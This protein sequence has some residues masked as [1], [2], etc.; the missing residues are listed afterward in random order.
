MMMHAEVGYEG[1]CEMHM[2]TSILHVD[3]I[4][5]ATAVVLNMENIVENSRFFVFDAVCSRQ[6]HAH[7]SCR[8]KWL[9]VTT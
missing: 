2:Y 5:D 7:L 1:E 3:F 4:F 9:P 6:E 8:Y